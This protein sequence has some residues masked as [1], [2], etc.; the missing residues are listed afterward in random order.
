MVSVA[1]VGI[2]GCASINVAGLLD[3]LRKA[4]RAQQTVLGSNTCPVF[5]PFLVGLNRDPVRFLD[6]VLV[7]P[8]VSAPEISAPD[9]VAVP[10]WTTRSG[11]RWSA[12]RIGSG[13]WR[14]GSTLDHGSP[15]APERFWP[16]RR[17][18]S[19]GAEPR[20]TGSQRRSSIAAIR[21][22][23]SRWTR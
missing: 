17:A 4:D 8:A 15:R 10:A 1:V 13:G 14:S 19:T 6:G 2:G 18:C 3:A 16:P 9:V 12:T 11:R 23:I 7:Q 21:G 22:S 5:E 20:L